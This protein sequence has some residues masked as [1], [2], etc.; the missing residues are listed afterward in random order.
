VSTISIVL[1]KLGP[2]DLPGSRP[3]IG[4]RPGEGPQHAEPPRARAD[5]PQRMLL[6]LGS[7]S[8]SNRSINRCRSA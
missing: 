8:G 2:G 5:Q 7:R 1:A 6:D 3:E 4:R